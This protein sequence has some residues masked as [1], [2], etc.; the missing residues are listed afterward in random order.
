MVN[1][2]ID[3]FTFQSEIGEG[4]MAIVYKAFD[5]NFADYVAIKLLKKEYVYNKNVRARF[6][7]E[8]RKLHQLSHQNIIRVRRIIDAGDLV[9]FAMDLVAGQSLKDYVASNKPMKKNEI[10]N[11]LNQILNAL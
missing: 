4:G 2:R 6:I 7:A 3:E 10:K 5:H 1:E 8:A 9:A 11:F